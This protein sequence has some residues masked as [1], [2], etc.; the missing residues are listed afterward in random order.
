MGQIYILFC[1]FIFKFQNL[2]ELILS[3][4]R[5]GCA[6]LDVVFNAL[7][8]ATKLKALNISNNDI[9][10]VGARLLSKSLQLNSSLKRLNFDR[11]QIGIEGFLEI[12][13]GLKMLVLFKCVNKFNITYIGIIA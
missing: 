12:E 7:G 9:G 5:L 8:A 11:N 10:N 4:C 2:E 6:C 1:Y 3:D 13:H